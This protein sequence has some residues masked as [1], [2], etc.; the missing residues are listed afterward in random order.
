MTSK[1]IQVGRCSF[2]PPEGFV[3]QKESS[4]TSPHPS[5]Y[6]T[7]T[8]GTTPI[9]ITLTSTKVYPDVPDFSN[10]PE[11]MNPVAYPVSITLT[12]FMAHGN[13]YPMDHLRKT[14]QVLQGHFKN[15]KISFYKKYMVGKYQAALSQCSF[16]TNFRIYRLNC[17]WF[18]EKELLVSTMMVT[19]SGVEKGWKDLRRFVES[20][21]L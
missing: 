20:V 13:A 15:F 1:Q 3:V 12:T 4:L 11:D 18:A 2:I 17:A 8:D 10:C 16:V 6:M 14:D 7:C 21:H 9:C 19:E 5:G